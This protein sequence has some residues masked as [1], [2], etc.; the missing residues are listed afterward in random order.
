MEG[1][2]SAAKSPLNTGSIVTAKLVKKVM[3]SL[4]DAFV[5][6]TTQKSIGVQGHLGN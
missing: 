2:T 6:G 1:A 3:C 5:T 4:P